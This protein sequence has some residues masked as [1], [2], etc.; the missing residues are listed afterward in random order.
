MSPVKNTAKRIIKHIPPFKQI[1]R[2]TNNLE[3]RIKQLEAK[4]KS[5][6]RMLDWLAFRHAMESLSIWNE[7]PIRKLPGRNGDSPYIIVSFTS[8][9][10]RVNSIEKVLTALYHQ[11]RLP[12]EIILSLSE[13]DFPGLEKDLPTSVL[14]FV[15]YG[16]TIHWENDDLKSHKKY[17]HAMIEHPDDIVVTVDDDLFYDSNLISDLVAAHLRFPKA[18]IARRAHRLLFDGSHNLKPYEQWD[19]NSHK[20][21]EPRLDLVPTGVGGVLYPPH[22][23]HPEAFDTDLIRTIALYEDDLWLKIMSARIGTPVVSIQVPYSPLV[24]LPETQEESLWHENVGAGKNDL[25]LKE[26]IELLGEEGRSLLSSIEA[27]Q[28]SRDA[29]KD[30]LSNRR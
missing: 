1:I 7:A 6:A 11:T 22:S 13:Y 10:K 27:D 20:T 8:Y 23:V 18:I 15:D 25:C 17:R 28:L 29:K 3:K 21:D 26:L 24:Y 16:L 2:K 5:Q 19:W 14:R 4:S 9:N 30:E 12:N